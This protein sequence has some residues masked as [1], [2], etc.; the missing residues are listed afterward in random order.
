MPSGS[1]LSASAHTKQ[2]SSPGAQACGDGANV[3]AGLAAPVASQ[4]AIGLGA[5]CDTVPGSPGAN[6]NASGVALVLAAARLL[7]DVRCRDA[8]VYFALFDQEE[9]GLVGS[10]HFAEMLASSG[11]DVE[12]HTIDQMGWDAD[13]DRAVELERP[14]PGML[15]DYQAARAA[16]GFSM[17][18]TETDTGSTDHVRFREH[19]IPA[20]GLTEE[21]VSGA[22][23]PHYHQ[24]SDTYPTVDFDYLASTTALVVT[25]LERAID[26]R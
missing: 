5:P 18:L 3:S 2:R 23:T 10:W 1:P 26:A 11:L 9:V 13:G 22:T 24:P 19:G 7:A 15:A 12:A 8:R 20:V 21:F 14:S 25:T 16:G 17:P 6:D 4:R